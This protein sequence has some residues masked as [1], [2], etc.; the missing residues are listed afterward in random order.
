MSR[1]ELA[2]SARLRLGTRRPCSP[3]LTPIRSIMPVQRKFNPSQ[4]FKPERQRTSPANLPKTAGPS[5]SSSDTRIPDQS[6]VRSR[7]RRLA[8][9]E[10]YEVEI[11]DPVFNT[12]D[13][14]RI[15]GVRPSRL[16][17]WRQRGVGPEYLQ[18]DKDGIRYELSS[19]VA[20]KAS[21]RVRP[22]RQP[23]PGRAR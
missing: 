10:P 3:E 18:Y 5:P 19:L 22:S 7:L 16:E 14:A 11:D 9:A 1:D 12:E 13:A 20:F 21:R 8:P 23:H 15:L 17:K 2:F 6:D 4:Y